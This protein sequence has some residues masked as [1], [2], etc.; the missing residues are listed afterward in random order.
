LKLTLMANTIDN[1]DVDLSVN[2]DLYAT[3]LYILPLVQ[4]IKLAPAGQLV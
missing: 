1:H 4:P 3:L 2:T